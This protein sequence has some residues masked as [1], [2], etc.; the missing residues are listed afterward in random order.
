[1]SQCR[2]CQV[3]KFPCP[4]LQHLLFFACYSL[5]PMCLKMAPQFSFWI[6]VALGWRTPRWHRQTPKQIK[7]LPGKPEQVARCYK[8]SKH[9]LTGKVKVGTIFLDFHIALSV[10]LLYHRNAASEAA[11]AGCK[12]ASRLH[13]NVFRSSFWLDLALISSPKFRGPKSAVSKTAQAGCK[14]A[15]KGS[16]TMQH[17]VVI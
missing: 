3:L 5:H 9:R 2:R 16:K 11:Q 10:P 15:Q 6:Q 8:T 17:R 13:K 7:L 1:M 14:V 12:M 4:P